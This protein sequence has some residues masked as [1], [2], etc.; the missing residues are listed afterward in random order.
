MEVIAWDVV[1]SVMACMIICLIFVL[2]AVSDGQV[3]GLR[4]FTD[5]PQKRALVVR[6]LVLKVLTGCFVLILDS[7]DPKHV[8]ALAP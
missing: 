3:L 7:Y 6:R 5:I 2:C 8:G 1:V 4:Q